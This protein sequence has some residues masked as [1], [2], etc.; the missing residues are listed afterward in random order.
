MIIKVLFTIIEIIEFLWV[1]NL[2]IFEISGK[3]SKKE[4]LK[5]YR[6]YIFQM[7]IKIKIKYQLII[8]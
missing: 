3:F 7:D 5:I 4:E 8:N 6:Y 2:L 1:A